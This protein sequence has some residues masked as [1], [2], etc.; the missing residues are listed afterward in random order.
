MDSANLI[1]ELKTEIKIINKKKFFKNNDFIPIFELN[2]YYSIY[3][4]CN[5]GYFKLF[6][7][8]FEESLYKEVI[9]I[10]YTCEKKK[11]NKIREIKINEKEKIKRQKIAIKNKYDKINNARLMKKITI[12]E[13]N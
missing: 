2:T 10:F 7:N 3:K 6:K 11:V 8:D 5:D 13:Y 1:E 4:I 12:S 9:D